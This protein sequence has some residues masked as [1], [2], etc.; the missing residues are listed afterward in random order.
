MPRPSISLPC[1]VRYAAKN[2]VSPNAEPRLAQRGLAGAS[3]E[4]AQLQRAH[5]TGIPHDSYAVYEFIRTG[6]KPGVPNF[7][8][9]DLS[10]ADFASSLFFGLIDSEDP[11]ERISGHPDLFKTNLVNAN[12][13]QIGFYAL[14]L[15][16]GESGDGAKGD[17]RHYQ[18]PYGSAPTW[19][20]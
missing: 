19:E 12:L 4:G 13:K 16:R 5:F 8:C 2:L 17:D 10:E 9:A 6:E 11:T 7:A 15:M 14:P 18:S 3:F 1:Q 20:S